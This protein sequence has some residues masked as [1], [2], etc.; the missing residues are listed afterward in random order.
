MSQKHRA[1]LAAG[2]LASRCLMLAL[3][4]LALSSVAPAR[5]RAA[6][7]PWRPDTPLAA[8]AMLYLNS[9]HGSKQSLFEQSADMGASAIRV[10]LALTAIFAPDG[11][12]SWQEVDDVMALA[13]A[14]RLRPVGIVLATPWRISSCPDDPNSYKCPPVDLQ[15]WQQMV[16]ELAAHTRGVI[17][18][19]EIL[20]EPDGGWAFTGTAADYARMLRAGHD[21]ILAANPDAKIAIG[22][23]MGLGSRA[24][25]DQVLALAGPHAERLYDIANVH[26]R[27][28]LRALPRTVVAW[29]A[30]FAAHHA[31]DK[32]LWVTE[33]GYPSDPAYQYD[34]AYRYGPAA[35]AAYLRRALPVLLSAGAAR[36]FVTLRDNLAGQF[37][38][39]GVLAGGVGD[40]PADHPQVVRKPAFDAL[41]AL[42]A[43]RP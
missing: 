1:R 14:Y 5:A 19:F 39:E 35:Q 32:P 11:S 40:P 30:F 7:P 28:S 26:I 15:A 33:F 22:A 18:T 38:S 34:R 9:P 43:Q 36:I 3:C 8:H 42:V 37:A 2:G 27:A 21:A 16:S 41:R 4:A 17:D 31:G 20:N 12:E 10:D 24:W 29:R 6:A 23:T 25:L 13:R